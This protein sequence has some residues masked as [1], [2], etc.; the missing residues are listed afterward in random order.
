MPSVPSPLQGLQEKQA[1][2]SLPV[3]SLA[4]PVIL[5]WLFPALLQLSGEV[6]EK[7]VNAI[8]FRGCFS[9]LNSKVS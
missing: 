3:V 1:F 8:Q 5:G 4:L 2:S 6:R 9:K 7:H